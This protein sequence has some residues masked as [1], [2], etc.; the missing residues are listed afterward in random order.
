MDT[1]FNPTVRVLIIGCG[2]VGVPLGAAL[3]QCGHSV[4]GL[5]RSAVAADELRTAGITPLLGDITRPETLAALPGKFDW[6]INTV[7]SGKG[8]AQ[9]YRA[10][11]LEGTQNII[12]WLAP[13]SPQKFIYTSSTS[14]YAQT[15]GEVVDESSATEP[16]GETSRLLV[17][18]ERLLLDA[19]RTC[20]FP[21]V[22]LRVAGIY[23]PTRGHLFQQFLRDEARITGDG[24]RL[25]NMIHLDDVVGSIIAALERGRA[26]D[27]FNVADEEPVSQLEFFHWLAAT[28]NKPLP[29]S[30]VEDAQR[31]RGVT[32]KRV[33][34]ARLKSA[35]G[36]T[37]KH[38]TFRE[39][40]AAEMRR[41]GLI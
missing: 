11:Y 8:G 31:K 12:D 13:Q 38:A 23:G 21:A 22:I 2:Y 18:T 39:G 1:R 19:A 25:L 30:A 20:N 36:Y 29:P 15:D 28:L 16:T 37:L 4:F 35:L 41:L 40:Y 9:E 33:S 26:G 5:R 6:V 17:E 14:V 10:V 27:V 34:N 3:A 32:N 24:S 7:S